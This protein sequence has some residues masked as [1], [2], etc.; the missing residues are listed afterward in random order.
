[1]LEPPVPAEPPPG[2]VSQGNLLEVL[3]S[4]EEMTVTRRRNKI[5]RS[6]DNIYRVAVV[7]PAICD[8]VQFTPREVSIRSEVQSGSSRVIAVPDPRSVVRP[9]RVSV[10]PRPP[11]TF[12]IDLVF[13]VRPAV[14]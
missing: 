11:G 1:M 5:L 2:A 10:A 7:D 8:V 3:S 14:R 4:S 6:K 9:P 12:R 13:D